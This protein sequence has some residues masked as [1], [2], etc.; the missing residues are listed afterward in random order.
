MAVSKKRKKK[1]EPKRPWKRKLFLIAFICFIL[2][3]AG[4]AG[5]ILLKNIVFFPV[6]QI[7]VVGN[8][9]L[10]DKEIASL[11]KLKKGTSILSVSSREI[12]E[13]LISSP[14]IKGV[15]L[16]KELPNRVIIRVHEAVPAALF[17]KKDSYYLIDNEGE[18]LERVS[19]D[20]RFLPV[21]TG[22]EKDGIAVQEA[23]QFAET[24]KKYG[25]PDME[26]I[27]IAT[28]K[29]EDMTVQYG[30]TVIKVGYG[31]YE[32]KIQRYLELRDEI[33]RRAIPVDYI[34]LRYDKRLVVKTVEGG[35][36]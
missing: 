19:T 30:A 21:I 5:K 27:E 33:R 8:R 35:V 14:W 3:S 12:V 28:G 16:R 31:N 24:V 4:Y 26:K 25:V 22:N 1:K 34:D 6:K 7:E 18:F 17:R 9:H 20:E 2:A 23:I 10:S 36:E 29:L 15:S 32:D 11:S 13:R